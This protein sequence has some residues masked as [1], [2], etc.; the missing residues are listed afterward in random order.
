MCGGNGT[1]VGSV[2]PFRT[3][4]CIPCKGTGLADKFHLKLIA[5]WGQCIDSQW[6]NWIGWSNFLHLKREPSE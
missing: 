4:F 3:A 2:Q 1:I 5:E 6:N